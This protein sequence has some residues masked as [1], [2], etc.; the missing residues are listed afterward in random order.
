MG[1]CDSKY[2]ETRKSSNNQ[3]QILDTKN[4]LTPFYLYATI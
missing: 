2:Q 3:E 1:V 4:R